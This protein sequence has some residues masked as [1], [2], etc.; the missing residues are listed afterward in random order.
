MDLADFDGATQR[1]SV[2]FKIEGH[3][4]PAALDPA[5]FLYDIRHTLSGC[6]FHNLLFLAKYPD[7][8]FEASESEVQKLLV[9][10]IRNSICECQRIFTGFCREKYIPLTTAE[11]VQSGKRI[12][13]KI[14]FHDGPLVIKTTV[15][16]KVEN[17][18]P[19]A[20]V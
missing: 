20:I 11:R 3:F 8:L 12:S 6:I 16:F 1:F 9:Q 5:D 17:L 10:E 15:Y 19:Q 13:A 4:H 18:F 2:K 14:K 7:N